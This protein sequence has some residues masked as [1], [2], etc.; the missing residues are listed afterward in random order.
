MSSDPDVVS[1]SEGGVCTVNGTGVAYISM[2]PKYDCG[3]LNGGS[4]DVNGG[5]SVTVLKSRS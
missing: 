4:P 5:F 1:I 2:C 3:Y